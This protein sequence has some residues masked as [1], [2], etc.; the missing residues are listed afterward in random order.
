METHLPAIERLPTE[1][2]DE[3]LLRFAEKAGEFD[4][5]ADES[6]DIYTLEDGEPV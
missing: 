2:S 4:F 6:E 1:A 3:E 5:L